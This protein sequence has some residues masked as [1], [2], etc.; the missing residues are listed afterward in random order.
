MLNDINAAPEWQ[1]TPVR[2]NN[3]GDACIPSVRVCVCVAHGVRGRRGVIERH[4]RRVDTVLTRNFSHVSHLES[5]LWHITHTSCGQR[6]SISN[7]YV[8]FDSHAVGKYAAARYPVCVPYSRFVYLSILIAPSYT[9]NF[10]KN[11]Q[12]ITEADFKSMF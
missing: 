11:D 5:I 4:M 1:L 2:S 10:S 3:N 12:I 8:H 9:Y 7:N 6:G